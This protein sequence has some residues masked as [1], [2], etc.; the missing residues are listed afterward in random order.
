MISQKLFPPL[1]PDNPRQNLNH[2][3]NIQPAD[4][5][6]ESFLQNLFLVK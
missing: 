5:T 4:I 1:I 6:S 2:Q 3:Q